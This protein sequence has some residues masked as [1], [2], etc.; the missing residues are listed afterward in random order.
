MRPMMMS[1]DCTSRTL[2]HTVWT[3]S[4]PLESRKDTVRG[5]SRPT[6]RE[7]ESP[8]RITRS[9]GLLRAV[10]VGG[11]W[12]YSLREIKMLP[13][14]PVSRRPDVKCIGWTRLGR[15]IDPGLTNGWQS[16]EECSDVEDDRW[17]SRA[18]QSCRSGLNTSGDFDSTL[19]SPS[20]VLKWRVPQ[21]P[22]YFQVGMW[23]W[24]HWHVW[25]ICWS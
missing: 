5:I 24:S 3:W 10:A 7:L 21:C 18:L 1:W 15:M 2:F 11:S 23:T 9:T 4:C 20:F 8:S 12:L 16:N 14:A 22:I 17:S 13:C 6:K 25:T 19:M